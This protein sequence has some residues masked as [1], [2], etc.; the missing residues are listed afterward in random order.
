[1]GNVNGGMMNNVASTVMINM[2][3]S[4]L[5][6]NF[7]YYYIISLMMGFDFMCGFADTVRGG[8]KAMGDSLGKLASAFFGR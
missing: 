7:K 5:R 2:N 8:G 4:C 1:M 3:D 6:N